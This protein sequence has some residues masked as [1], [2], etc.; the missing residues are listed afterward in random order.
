[1]NR[2]LKRVYYYFVRETCGDCGK[3][4]FHPGFGIELTDFAKT[5]FYQ[6][7]WRITQPY[8]PKFIIFITLLAVWQSSN[9]M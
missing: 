4:I 8:D 2:H 5:E 3:T 1:M 7:W 9:F 6:T